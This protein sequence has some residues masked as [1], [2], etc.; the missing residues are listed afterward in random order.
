MDGVVWLC[1]A[2]NAVMMAVTDPDMFR[3]VVELVDEFDRMRS[4]LMLEIGGVDLIVERGWYSSVDFWPFD[5]DDDTPT[6]LGGGCMRSAVQSVD[7]NIA[8]FFFILGGLLLASR[9]MRAKR[10]ERAARKPEPIMPKG[11]NV[12]LSEGNVP[13]QELEFNTEYDGIRITASGM[14]ELD[15]KTEYDP[16][17]DDPL[18]LAFFSSANS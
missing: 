1:G 7:P 9:V 10:T 12:G 2:E 8:T 13:Y 15:G 3:Q 11:F 17:S 14:F 5:A 6:F 16:N 18:H 4:D